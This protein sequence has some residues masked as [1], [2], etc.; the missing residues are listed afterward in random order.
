M[1]RRNRVVQRRYN[2]LWSAFQ[3]L[4]ILLDAAEKAA[5]K[6]ARIV[7]LDLHV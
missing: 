6:L 5:W 1:A 7:P 2:V 3:L 4:Q